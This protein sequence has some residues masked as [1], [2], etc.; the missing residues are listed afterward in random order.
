[1]CFPGIILYD[2]VAGDD[3]D[4]LYLGLGRSDGNFLYEIKGLAALAAAPMA[5]ARPRLGA[6]PAPPAP[7]HAEA[8]GPVRTSTRTRARA[9]LDRAWVRGDTSPS[10]NSPHAGLS[11]SRTTAGLSIKGAEDFPPHPQPTTAG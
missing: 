10:I 8:P 5:A 11:P 4:G 1:V 7:G 6:R 2:A 9:Q 3:D